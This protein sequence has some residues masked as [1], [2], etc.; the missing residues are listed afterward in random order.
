MTKSREP[1]NRARSITILGVEYPSIKEA[2]I[3]LG[4]HQTTLG[5]R[6]RDGWQVEEAIGRKPHK[7]TMPGKALPHSAAQFS[8]QNGVSLGLAEQFAEGDVVG[9]HA[10]RWG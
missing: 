8:G 3:A 6:L 1:G 10:P 5:R 7:R 4:L 2:A 9:V